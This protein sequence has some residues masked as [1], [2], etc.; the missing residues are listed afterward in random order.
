MAANGRKV[1]ADFPAIYR[2]D[3][4]SEA[5]ARL[6]AAAIVLHD[7][8]RLLCNCGSMATAL[9]QFKLMGLVAK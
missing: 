8:M 9:Y 1:C 6:I 7:P 5:N 3:G 4:E 2:D